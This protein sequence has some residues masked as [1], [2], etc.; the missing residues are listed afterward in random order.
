MIIEENTIT[1]GWKQ[2]YGIRIRYD[3]V[4]QYYYIIESH[5]SCDLRTKIY[6]ETR[7]KV[8]VHIGYIQD[9]LI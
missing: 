2:V 9:I 5:V 4:L 3:N 1:K 7:H 8:R 6:Y